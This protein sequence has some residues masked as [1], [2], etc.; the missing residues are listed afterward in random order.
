MY[1]LVNQISRNP[2]KDK[3]RKKSQYIMD[4]LTIRKLFVDMKYTDKI[5]LNKP[6]PE[7]F[8]IWNVEKT[9]M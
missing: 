2:G 8:T 1:S 6:I 3:S 9:M 5:D 7:E 4:K